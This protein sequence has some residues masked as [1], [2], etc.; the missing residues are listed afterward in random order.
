MVSFSQW[1]ESHKNHQAIAQLDKH[2]IERICQKQ[3]HHFRDSTLSPGPTVQCFAWQIAMGNVTC[4]AVRHHQDGAFSAS[5]YCQARQRLSLAVLE[6]LSRQIADQALALAHADKEHCWHGH[7]VFRIDGSSSQLFDSPQLRK[8]FGCSGKQKPGCGYPTAHLL[9]LVG[10][11]GVGIDC[12]A[13][14]LRTGDV[15]GA[16]KMHEHLQ[17]GDL[18]IGD[19]L[20]GGWGHLHTLQSQ[21]L[22]GLFPAHHS[23]AIGWGA[24]GKHQTSRRFVKSLGYLDQ[25]VEY[26]KPAK[27]PNWMSAKV[28]KDAPQWILVREVQRQITVAA[29]RRRIVLITT[30][31]DPKKYPAKGLTKLLKQRWAIELNLRSLKTT[32]AA[33]RLRCQ[34]V[35]GVKK[36]LLMYLIMYNLVRL[37]ML[38][39]AE[40]QRVPFDRVSF[41][42]SLARLRYGTGTLWV[43]LKTN[44]LRPDR[45]EPRVVKQRPKSYARMTHP[46]AQLRAALSR[47]K[48]VAA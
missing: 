3:G 28:F 23:R 41:A 5:A 32:M 10:P 20:F 9:M 30:L 14:P 48:R 4:D 37:L 39:A 31:L 2:E 27:R 33:E 1:S 22:H 26:R 43:D 18:L 16:T 45:I 36:E 42:D 21:T 8:H 44:P 25:L 15:S 29:R 12:I 35:Q 40:R 38:K 47:Q 11:G 46:R 7:R 24:G 19:G 13:S 6:E 17:A 34:T